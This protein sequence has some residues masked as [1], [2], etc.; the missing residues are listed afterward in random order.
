MEDPS[1]W[2]NYE[3]ELKDSDFSQIEI[4]RLVSGV[5]QVNSLDEDHIKAA[6]ERFLA[7]KAEVEEDSQ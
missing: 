2:L 7:G 1:T 4:N 3:K 6:R 5:L